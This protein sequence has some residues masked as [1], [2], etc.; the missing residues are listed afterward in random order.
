[1]NVL[2]TG[3]TGFVGGRLVVA[4]LEKTDHD[5]TVLV[6]DET[7]YESAESVTVVEGDVLEPNGLETALEDVDAAFY[8]IHAM[9]AHG[10]FADRDRRAARNFERAASAAGVERVIYLSGLGSDAEVLSAHL[11]SRH[12]VESVLAAGSTEVTVLR[13]AIIVGDGSASFRLLTQL[14]TRLPV[15]VTPRWIHTRCQ[16]IGID[17]VVAYCLAVLERPE[18]AG[19]TYEIGGPDV[20]TY[21]ELLA[22][23]AEIATGRRPLVLP[24]PILSPRL[25]AY[26]VGLVTDV[27]TAVA[28]PLIDGLRNPVVVED[29]RLERLVGLEPVSFDVAVRRALGHDTDDT[30]RT[31]RPEQAVE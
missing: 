14:A 18:T 20:L 7:A 13:A 1:M 12:E 25:S 16:P 26:W 9:G 6:R 11:E 10:D 23:T 8:L 22:T 19:E 17:D 3:A 30:T 31:T 5:V 29:D 15:M 24:V 21:R 27:P 4:L 28:Y 2:V